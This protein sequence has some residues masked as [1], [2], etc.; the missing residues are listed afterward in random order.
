M[1]SNACGDSAA[2]SF[3]I[4]SMLVDWRLHAVRAT[5]ICDVDLTN[6]VHL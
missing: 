4:P 2:P 5:V 6:V 3:T 1:S